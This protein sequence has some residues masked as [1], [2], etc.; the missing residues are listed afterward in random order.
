MET[1]YSCPLGLCGILRRTSYARWVI[2]IYDIWYIKTTIGELGVW[3]AAVQSSHKELLSC[4]LQRA[5]MDNKR[6]CNTLQFRK[7]SVLQF[8]KRI[9]WNSTEK[10]KPNCV[11]YLG[12]S[13]IYLIHRKGLMNPLSS[14]KIQ[15]PLT[16]LDLRLRT[17]PLYWPEAF[18][19][20]VKGAIWAETLLFLRPIYPST[21]SCQH[22]FSFQLNIWILN[23]LP[24]V[25]LNTGFQIPVILVQVWAFFWRNGISPNLASTRIL[26]TQILR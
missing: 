14:A 1:L 18:C 16:A 11:E 5:F 22:S 15:F 26:M 20:T 2:F 10:I 8:R 13:L 3:F 21:R 17:L 19:Q 24:L 12:Q 7:Q 25:R 23:R 9:N 4:R 6:F